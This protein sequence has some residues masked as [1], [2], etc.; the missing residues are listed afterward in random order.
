MGCCVSIGRT[1]KEHESGALGDVYTTE[2]RRFPG[3]TKVALER[4]V[5][6]QDLFEKG[7][8]FGGVL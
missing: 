1:P 8:D 4:G 2:V 5:Q 7:D 6:S 3:D